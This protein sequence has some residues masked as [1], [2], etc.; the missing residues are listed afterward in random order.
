MKIKNILVIADKSDPK[1]KAL[2]RAKL[3][4]D[5]HKASLHIVVSCYERL[6]VLSA[7]ISN[8]KKKEVQENILK[9]NKKW[10]SSQIKKEK[11]TRVSSY[12]SIW[13]KSIHEWV[14]KKCKK[15]SFDVIIKAGSNIRTSREIPINWHILRNGLVPVL[16]IAEKKWRKKQSIMVSL[17]LSS[18]VKSK[19]DLN[20]KLVEAGV[21]LATVMDVPLNF[22]FSLSCSPVLKELGIIE[23]RQLMKEA[24][25]KFLPIIQEMA[26]DF[27][28]AA[29][30]VH[31]K[32]GNAENVIPSIASKTAAGL[33][34]IGTVGRKG[35][36][37][38]LLGNTAER[39]LAL[40]KTNILV[41]QP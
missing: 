1:N 13:E 19:Q 7:K 15:E 37:G 12:E 3:M 11:L 31:I 32:V 39:I 38:K 18:K 10:L 9:E 27:D 23:P 41:I 21:L 16:L 24:R 20:R 34:I 4:A 25:Q 14:V 17:D 29:E 40:L 35:L 6:D 33:V 36:K 30:N 5:R 22:A 28:V 26:G 8:A 2:A